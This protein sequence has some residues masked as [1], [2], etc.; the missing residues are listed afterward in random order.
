MEV[1]NKST[2]DKIIFATLKLL[3]EKGLAGTTTCKI[4]EEACVSEVTI[5]RK[6]KNKENL[7]KIAKESYYDDFFIKLDKLFEY[8]EDIDLK[9]YFTSIWNNIVV[10]SDKEL[11]MFKIAIDELRDLSAVDKG[12][13][14]LADFIISKLSNFFQKQIDMGK[15][16]NINPDVAALNIF[17]ILFEAIVLWK[18]YGAHSIERNSDSYLNDFLDIFINGISV[19]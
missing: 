1:N 18:I 11:D 4:A 5:F 12:L 8:D 10:L 14:R 3:D 6:F 17:S 19:K 13:P 9:D 16:R 2:E 15:I 7:F